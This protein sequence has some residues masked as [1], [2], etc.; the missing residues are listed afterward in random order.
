VRVENSFDLEKLFV[1]IDVNW[2]QGRW[3]AM[4]WHSGFI[5]IEEAD[6]KGI[7]DMFERERKINFVGLKSDSF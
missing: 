2:R 7:V 5:W 6:M 4:R 3:Q 1:V